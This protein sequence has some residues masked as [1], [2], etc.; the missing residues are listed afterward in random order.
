ME[1]GNGGRMESWEW[2]AHGIPRKC[3]VSTEFR[4][5]GVSMESVPSSPPGDGEKLGKRSSGP[6]SEQR[7]FSPEFLL[8]LVGI[9]GQ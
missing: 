1:R 4:D 9:P 5:P 8:F 3:R 2:G 7:L 6:N